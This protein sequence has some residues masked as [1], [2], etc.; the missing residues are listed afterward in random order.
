MALA[1]R[2]SRTNRNKLNKFGFRLFSNS[3]NEMFISYLDVVNRPVGTSRTHPVFSH[4]V[5]LEEFVKLGVVMFAGRVRVQC[6]YIFKGAITFCGRG[7][8][9]S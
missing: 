3:Q 2:P 7:K 4:E 9:T 8:K 5:C 1:Y 6:T